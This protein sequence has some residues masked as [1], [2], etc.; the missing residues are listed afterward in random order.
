MTRPSLSKY[1][2]RLDYLLLVQRGDDP[3]PRVWERYLSDVRKCRNFKGALIWT[4]RVPV[5]QER[6][7]II[8]TMPPEQPIAVF[9]TRPAAVYHLQALQLVLKQIRIFQPDQLKEALRFLNI[10]PSA[11]NGVRQGMLDVDWPGPM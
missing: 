5:P 11:E 1:T 7:D 8:S 6:A 2:F 10:G 9:V 4:D 3:D